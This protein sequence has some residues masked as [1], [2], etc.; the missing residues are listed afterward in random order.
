MVQGK[1]PAVPEPRKTHTPTH[2]V[3]SAETLEPGPFLAALPNN[4]VN[5]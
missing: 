1:S 3:V 5:N 4:S 2:I